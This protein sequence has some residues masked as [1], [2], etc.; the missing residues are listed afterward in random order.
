[1]GDWP[2]ALR[3]LR[4]CLELEESLWVR[5]AFCCASEALFSRSCLQ[6]ANNRH[7]G[8]TVFNLGV[9]A[10]LSGDPAGALPHFQRAL[11][12]YRKHL[13]PDHPAIVRTQQRMA[14]LR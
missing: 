1:M 5:Q 10:Q 2:N 4:K 13:A 14:E 11:D 7:S 9:T 3:H 8:D 6:G 12:I